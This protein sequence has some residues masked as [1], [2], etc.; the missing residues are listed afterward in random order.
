MSPQRDEATGIRHR[1]EQS[2]WAVLAIV[3]VACVTLT[4]SVLSYIDRE[5]DQARTD[6]HL[7]EIAALKST[8]T[9]DLRGRERTHSLAMSERDA[10]IEKLRQQIGDLESNLTSFTPGVSVDDLFDIGSRVRG[11]SS[12]GNIPEG[13]EPIGEGDLF[14]PRRTPYWTMKTTTDVDLMRDVFGQ[15]HSTIFKNSQVHDTI[16]VWIADQTLPVDGHAFYRRCFHISQCAFRR[17]GSSRKPVR[18]G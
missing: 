1:I 17:P 13:A 15:E 11:G 5:G 2:V 10:T 18:L 14:A 7:A 8:H 9:E 12:T 4:Y 3:G 6:I 16:H